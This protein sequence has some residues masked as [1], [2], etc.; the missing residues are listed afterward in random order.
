MRTVVVRVAD[1]DLC[2][3]LA[4]MREWLA[5]HGYDP[6]RFVYDQADDALVISVEFPNDWQAE[7]FATRFDGQAPTTGEELFARFAAPPGDLSG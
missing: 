5:R 3:D 6:A 1:R 4:A 7:A 2:G